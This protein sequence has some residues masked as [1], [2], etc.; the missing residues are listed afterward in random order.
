VRQYGS[1]HQ[2]YKSELKNSDVLGTT[3]YLYDMVGLFNGVFTF[4]SPSVYL[5]HRPIYRDLVVVPISNNSKYPAM[6]VRQMMRPAGII[7]LESTDIFSLRPTDQT[8]EGLE[9][10]RQVANGLFRPTLKYWTHPSY[11]TLPLNFGDLRNPVPA[12]LYYDARQ[13]DCWGNQTHCRTI[14]EDT[15]RP[16]LRI[17]SDIWLSVFGGEMCSE[18]MFVDP[19]VEITTVNGMNQ[20]PPPSWPRRNLASADATATPVADITVFFFGKTVR[21]DAKPGN[22]ARLPYPIKTRGFEAKETLMTMRTPD[23]D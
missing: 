4:T 18:A 12:S 6:G 5:A 17:R 10:A 11:E 16:R 14:T 20:P 7:R 3:S 22:Q 2:N 13:N 8:L 1:L 15:Y 9:Y 23:E 21:D 19:D